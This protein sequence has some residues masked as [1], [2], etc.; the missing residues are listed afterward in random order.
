MPIRIYSLS[1]LRDPRGVCGVQKFFRRGLV[2]HR[3]YTCKGEMNC[4]IN[5]RTRNACRYCRYVRC[6][7]VGMS[8]DGQL[9]C[10]PSISMAP[11]LALYSVCLSVCLSCIITCTLAWLG[12]RAFS[13]A[14]QVVWNSLPA[15]VCEADSLF[16]FKCLLKT[17]LFTFC[18]NN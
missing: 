8:R 5:P 9:S 7:A 16:S 2:E 1:L 11:H 13:V 3:S 6:L 10:W 15:A 14:G 17:H 12:D 4:V 18:F